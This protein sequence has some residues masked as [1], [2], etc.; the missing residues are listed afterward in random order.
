VRQLPGALRAAYS[1]NG[2]DDEEICHGLAPF[3]VG[4]ST[5][6]ALVIASAERAMRLYVDGQLVND[7][8]LARPLSRIQDVNNWL[9]HSNYERDA[10][11]GGSFDEFRIYAAALTSEQLMASFVAGPDAEP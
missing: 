5:H 7:C 9:G 1:E 2:A 11:L 8:V 4:L 10:D 3:P 6:V